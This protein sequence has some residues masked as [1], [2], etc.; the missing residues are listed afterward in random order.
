MQALR[1]PQGMASRKTPRAYTL[2]QLA[3]TV[4]QLHHHAHLSVMR[5]NA[6][7]ASGGPMTASTTPAATSRP[8]ASIKLQHPPLLLV[9]FTMTCIAET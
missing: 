5:P 7:S 6:A 1:T 4:D 3:T 9:T 2:H 8:P